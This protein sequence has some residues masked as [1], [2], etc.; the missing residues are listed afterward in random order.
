MS[1][2]AE[3]P[4]PEQNEG[5][6]DSEDGHPSGSKHVVTGVRAPH[7]LVLATHCVWL[8]LLEGGSGVRSG[9]KSDVTRETC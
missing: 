8:E 6:V 5:V 1:A 2:V 9:K 7:K 4:L 3:V